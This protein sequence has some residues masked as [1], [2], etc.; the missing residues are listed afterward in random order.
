MIGI[1]FI[2]LPISVNIDSAVP[3]SD[4]GLAGLRLVGTTAAVS[5]NNQK[6]RLSLFS[7]YHHNFFDFRF[8]KIRTKFAI[9]YLFYHTTLVLTTSIPC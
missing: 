3:Q 4:C 9:K 6:Q 1:L 5:T 2:A 8:I 7:F